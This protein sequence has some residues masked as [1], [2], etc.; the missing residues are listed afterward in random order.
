[1]RSPAEQKKSLP[2]FAKP[3]LPLDE[4]HEIL[5]VRGNMFWF[6][7]LQGVYELQAENIVISFLQK[8]TALSCNSANPILHSFSSNQPLFFFT[9]S[10]LL[11][12]FHV[13]DVT[14]KTFTFQAI[15]S[16]MNPVF[17]HGKPLTLTYGS[18][19]EGKAQSWG[20]K[21]SS[22]SEER[23]MVSM[24]GRCIT[25]A[26][27]DESFSGLKEDE[28]KFLLS[29]YLSDEDMPDVDDVGKLRVACLFC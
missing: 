9:F 6:D 26:Q 15:S 8:G 20:V 21:V 28:R 4:T 27:R 29:G 19:H 17:Y 22:P 2:I 12:F 25:E 7:P 16:E 23:A 14:G 1:M 5:A 13:H 18:S 10:L 3:L 24:Y 11:D